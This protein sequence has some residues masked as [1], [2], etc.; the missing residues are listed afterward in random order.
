[1]R[2]RGR[3]RISGILFLLLALAVQ[4]ISSWLTYQAVRRSLD[5]QLGE[6]LL[7]VAGAAAAGLSP[8]GVRSVSSE[9]EA[10]PHWSEFQERINRV[11]EQTLVGNIFL[12]DTEKRNLFD[13]RERFPLGFVNP[14]LDLHYAP[15]TAALA[16]VPAA[17]PLYQ[18]GSVYLKAGFAPVL[19]G[20][21]VVAVLGVEGDAA[22]FSVLADLKRTFLW[23]GLL[24]FLS[25]LVL[26][27][28]FLR[29]LRGLG[30]AEDTVA[31]TSALAVAG[32]LAAMV[33]HEIRNPLAVI[34]SRAERV[35]AKIDR[36]ADREEI[37][38]WF[39]VI[40]KEV[41]RLNAV[42]SNY[43]SFARPAAEEAPGG[44]VVVAVEAVR[45]LM[46]GECARKGI[47][48][49]IKMALPPD[50]SVTLPTHDIQQIL[51]N[52]LL[53]GVQ[54]METHGGRLDISARLVNEEV[55]LCV[56]D[57]GPGFDPRLAETIFDP[58]YTSKTAG[59]GLG[60]AIVKMLVQRGGG[61]IRASAAKEGG[62][63][64]EVALPALSAENGWVTKDDDEER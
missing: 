57:T 5:T 53:N 18:V 52:L 24:G 48:L 4:N 42:L 43:L 41:D 37:L 25:M 9:G 13:R 11:S 34:R 6:R 19:D 30:K 2:H 17:T 35:K 20:H 26:G 22:F 44:R 55:R 33:A 38:E 8:D 56:K 47:E 39:E 51:V 62:A 3:L 16:G 63:L 15:V 32:E 10:S 40:P 54:A 7:A 12:F 27:F 36:G 58:F 31:Q 64:F 29:V 14:L 1:M 46:E 61:T 49:R 28:L 59:S 21:E 45:G 23:T 50:L 60:L